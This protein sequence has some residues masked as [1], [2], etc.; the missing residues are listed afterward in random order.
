MEVNATVMQINSTWLD[1]YKNS[2]D[3]AVRKLALDNLKALD[4]WDDGKLNES[5]G[6]IDGDYPNLGGD[7]DANP[8]PPITPDEP[9]P[10]SLDTPDDPPP[11]PPPAND[12]PP[13]TPPPGNTPR[14]SL[15]DIRL[16]DMSDEELVAAFKDGHW[17]AN[18][19]NY[20]DDE[21][22]KRAARDGK[23][24]DDEKKTIEDAIASA[25]SGPV[26]AGKADA[27]AGTLGKTDTEAPDDVSGDEPDDDGDAP[28]RKD[29]NG[30]NLS[31][32]SNDELIKLLKS[33]Y[34]NAESLN[35]F[36][37]EFT[38]RAGRDG[39]TDD[40]RNKIDR[41][42]DEGRAGKISDEKAGALSSV[43]DTPEEKGEGGG[44]RRPIDGV[45]LRSMTNNELTE[46]LRDNHWDDN[47]LEYFRDELLKRMK[48]GDG[49]LDAEERDAVDEKID[50]AR[51]GK[52]TQSESDD[53]ENRL[54]TAMI[55]DDDDYNV[56][57]MALHEANRLEMVNRAFVKDDGSVDHDARN[58]YIT[59]LIGDDGLSEEDWRYIDERFYHEYRHIPVVKN[60]DDFRNRLGDGYHRYEA[61]EAFLEKFGDRS[62][63]LDT[64]YVRFAGSDG[65][66]SEEELKA[67]D[68]YIDE[69]A[70]N[71]SAAS[72]DTRMNRFDEDE[73]G[74]PSKDDVSPYL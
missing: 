28:E 40:E 39:L 37:D 14:K 59:D 56:G 22:K 62:D 16:A 53:L 29:L 19:L 60:A 25:R 7:V 2:T 64:M 47:A 54:N 69:K 67:M 24:T 35:Y 21:F 10:P 66:M 72:W 17:D 1:L 52:L 5:L 43:L 3:P 6:E 18:A 4:I 70:T 55:G 45:N 23:L 9:S 61:V 46:L 15:G 57:S 30:K 26:P 13:E 41:T 73:D 51:S 65:K 36:H 38:K 71:S 31:E 34:W 68:K 42:I 12:A 49:I 74:L 63:V 50:K 33:E 32:L 8:P 27:V 11:A 20:F 44:G 48:E 58:R